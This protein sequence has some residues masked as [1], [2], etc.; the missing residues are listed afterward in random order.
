[1]SR[2]DSVKERSHVDAEFIHYVTNKFGV[3]AQV[4]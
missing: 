3:Y 1:M 4:F 2:C